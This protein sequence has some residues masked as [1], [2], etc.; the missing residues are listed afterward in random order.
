MPSWLSEYSSALDARDARE[1][2]QVRFIKACSHSLHPTCYTA[3]LTNADTKLADRT[4]SLDST[5]E[6]EPTGAPPSESPAQRTT[7][8]GFAF[9]TKSP[10]NTAPSDPTANLSPTDAL[11]RLRADLASTQRSRAALEAQ[12]KELPTLKSQSA[13]SSQRI[14]ELE[15][16]KARLER[17]VKDREDEIKGKAKLV[18]DAHDETATLELELNTA[19]ARSKALEKENRELVD[20]WMRRMGEEADEMNRKS[21]W[22]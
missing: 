18:E 15:R 21:N 3:R 5:Q 7:S 17:R 22:Q 4:A 14:A 16:D 11:A 8:P 12:L 9:R 10:T 1:Q 19:V 20:R 13:R 6:P 2:S